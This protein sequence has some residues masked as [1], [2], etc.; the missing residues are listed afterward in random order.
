M[1]CS[2]EKH[3][4]GR[5]LE[6]YH[7]ENLHEQGIPWVA[8]V[9]KNGGETEEKNRNYPRRQDQNPDV[10]FCHQRDVPKGPCDGEEAI[11]RHCA[12]AGVRAVKE[13]EADFEKDAG[14]S[15]INRVKAELGSKQRR[16]E[17]QSA[18]QISHGQG[19]D[20]PVCCGVKTRSGGDQKNNTTIS[21]HC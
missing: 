10:L 20:K 17:R 12:N 16:K 15:Q 19:Q 8:S 2:Y 4:E 18:T 5:D 1:A 13:G 14:M 6:D 9:H 3:H 21:N 7:S 11:H